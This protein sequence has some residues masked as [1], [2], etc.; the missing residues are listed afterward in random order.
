MAEYKA[1]SQLVTWIQG[2]LE[3][4][5]DS[6]DSNYLESWKE[7]ER[8]W[9][10]EWAAQD[11]LRESERSRIVSP[12]LQEAIENH[13]SEIEEGA[14]GSGDSLFSIDDDMADKED[15]DIQYLQQYMKE[16]F[17][18]NGLRKNVGD[19]ILLASIYGTGIGEIILKKTKEL[20]PATQPMDEVESIAI[21]TVSKDKLNVVLNP[22]SP[23][24]FLIDPNATSIVDAMGVAIEEF[25]SSHKIAE[26]M[27]SG[28][29]KKADLGGNAS[30]D[31]DLEES[32]IDEEYDHDK[33]K[34][35][36]YYGLVP[37]KLIDKPETGVVDFVEGGTD[38][39]AEYG[40][41]V[42]A[43][44]VIG[45]D[46]VILKAERSPYMM[47]DRPVVAYQDDTVPNRFW[48]RGVAEK[49][50]NM[51]KAIDA[52][53]RAHLDSLALTTAPMMGMDATRLPRGAKFEIRPGKT[54]LTNGSPGEVLMPFKFGQTDSSNLTTAKEF[55]QMLLQATNTLNTA[56]DMKQPTGG[57]LSVTLSTIL[58]KNKRTLV[59][60]QENFLI[61][62]I[63]KAAHRF[64]QFD[65]EHFPVADYKF[66]P[67]GSLGNLAKEVEQIQ[68]IN[69]LKTLGPTSAIVPLLLDGIVSNSS[70][71]N[72]SEI[73]LALTK[74]QEEAKQQTQQQQ[75]IVMA[76]AQAL[77]QLQNSEAQENSAQAQNYMVDAQ[78]K[79]Q[80]VQAK[81]M[82]AL[83]TNLPSEAEEQEAEFKRRV[84]TAELMLKEQEL[85]MKEKDMTD[86]KEIVKM[87]MANKK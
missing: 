2:H 53:L 74:S 28:V 46:N 50:F 22:I 80:E 19:I 23:Q 71:P 70:L 86:N 48:G 24:N 73:K 68:F 12:A 42:E 75:Q 4:W 67:N 87:Q 61:P 64:M 38:L 72:K 45:N 33:V 84:Q 16:C 37:E 25:V 82:T 76:Q 49:G 3:D 5:R 81:M 51:Q 15:K 44:V 78:M 9:R 6:R 36:R 20:T 11:K 69:L 8:L 79:P 34:I 65:P 35:V 1:P 47:K 58:K 40:D 62:F 85:Q 43:I 77:I 39:L 57:E 27:E 10:G 55:Q 66:V 13:A 59:N 29:Y 31:L 41:L 60:F 30:N 18:K 83:A 56:A 63:E 7:Y 32:W 21:G 54:L 14:F 17:K 26:N 52:Q